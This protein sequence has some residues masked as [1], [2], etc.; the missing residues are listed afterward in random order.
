MQFSCSTFFLQSKLSSGIA[1][2][3]C[4]CMINARNRFGFYM[5]VKKKLNLKCIWNGSSFG[6]YGMYHMDCI[7]L[8][9][10][11]TSPNGNLAHSKLFEH[12][13]I[14][15]VK[16]TF[17]HLCVCHYCETT[18][19]TPTNGLDRA[20]H[21]LIV[22]QIRWGTQFVW[23]HRAPHY[24]YYHHYY[25]QRVA[26]QS[27]LFPGY[28]CAILPLIAY[29]MYVRAS[30][31]LSRLLSVS[32]ARRYFHQSFYLTLFLSPYYKLINGSTTIYPVHPDCMTVCLCVCGGGRF[33]Y[34]RLRVQ[35]TRL[36]KQT[37]RLTHM[38]CV[39][40]MWSTLSGCITRSCLPSSF[41]DKI[42]HK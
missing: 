5:R 15:M 13:G 21:I 11:I 29:L 14:V 1:H 30:Y 35:F 18:T 38:C 9:D 37:L 19:F 24:Y 26:K 10:V 36:F 12:W 23:W 3:V 42:I 27:L 20:T 34:L 28:N 2:H 39:H 33:T 16:F 41:A 22:S 4:V 7:A 25:Q 17:S 40:V 8:Y 31:R 32:F 6:W